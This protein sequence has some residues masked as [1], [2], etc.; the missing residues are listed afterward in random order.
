MTEFISQVKMGTQFNCALASS[1]S[2]LPHISMLR[3]ENEDSEGVANGINFASSQHASSTLK[4]GAEGAYMMFYAAWWYARCQESEISF[5]FNLRK[6][7]RHQSGRR[8]ASSK[9]WHMGSTSA[10][11]SDA[12]VGSDLIV[13]GRAKLS[14]QVHFPIRWLSP[15]TIEGRLEP[16]C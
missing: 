1:A 14:T 8:L 12:H 3:Q 10:D 13:N 16:T 5:D 4:F 15:S 6:V 7:F 11:F 9:T 2:P